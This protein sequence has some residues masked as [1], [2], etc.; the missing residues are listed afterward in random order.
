[1]QPFHREACADRTDPE[2]FVLPSG[3]DVRIHGHS[4]DMCELVARQRKT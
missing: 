1:M 4:L 3:N 2:W